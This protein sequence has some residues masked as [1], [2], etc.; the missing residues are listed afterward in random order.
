MHLR[1]TMLTADPL[2]FGE[3][4]DFIERDARPLIEAEPGNVGMSLKVKETLGVALV[5]T[6]WVSGDAMRESDR[7]VRATRVE[8]AHRANA[9]LSVES[10]Q[11]ASLVRTASWERGNGVRVTRLCARPA[12]LDKMV[13]TYEDTALPWRTET[14]GFRGAVLLAHP[15]TGETI[16]ETLW[17]DEEAL[18]GSR[19]AAAG[20]RVDTVNAT[21]TT[22]KGLEEYTQVFNS[23]R[24]V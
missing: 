20:I 21:D 15:R 7:N 17:E 18:V 4:T 11:V 16:S 5:E 13:A 10:F 19:S 6:F 12:E 9:T 3:A 24:S 22:V 14:D 1:L 2:K 8:A 23:V